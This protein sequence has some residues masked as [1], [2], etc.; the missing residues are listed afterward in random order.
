MTL[1]QPL[2]LAWSISGCEDASPEALSIGL[3]RRRVAISEGSS[4][5]GGL[6]KL[7]CLM[8]KNTQVTD[9]GL[10]H[11]KR[12]E[13]LRDLR[14]SGTRV[15]DEGIESLQKDLPNIDR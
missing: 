12:L 2:G 11:L 1:R 15:T 13:D 8:L 3:S 14:L 5:L 10:V 4:L 7:Q 6:T 9:A